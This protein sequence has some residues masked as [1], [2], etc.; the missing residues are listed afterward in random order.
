LTLQQD[1]KPDVSSEEAIR[2]LQSSAG[3][4]FDPEIVKTFCNLKSN[5][6]VHDVETR[7]ELSL[8]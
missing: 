5:E 4:R 2:Q 7:D 8:V 6:Q 3:K 1:F